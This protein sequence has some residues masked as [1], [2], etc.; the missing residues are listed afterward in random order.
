[1]ILLDTHVWIWW[2]NAA[3]DLPQSARR[4]LMT[5]PPGEMAISLISCWEVAKLAENNRLNLDRPVQDWLLDAIA[6]SGVQVVALTIDILVASTRLPQPF[7]RD[8]ADQI[9][10]ATSRLLG[11]PLL[12]QDRQLLAYEHVELATVPTDG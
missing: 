7:H 9:V 2:V 12:T 10:V 11:I 4:L 5:T 8:P 1:M 6:K 3:P